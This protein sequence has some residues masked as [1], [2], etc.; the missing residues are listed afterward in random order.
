MTAKIKHSFRA[1]RS[2]EDYLNGAIEAGRWLRSQEHRT[3][4]GSWWEPHPSRENEGQT[5][6][7]HGSAGVILFFISLA[8][9]SGDKSFLDDAKRGADY[10][11]NALKKHG[12]D[13]LE[14][15]MA[16]NHYR[17]GTKYT[18]ISGGAAGIAYA[19]TELNWEL[20][21]PEE[22]YTETA[23]K[24]TE[25]IIDNA[26]EIP[27]GITWSRK[28]GFNF[29]SGTILYLLYAAEHY[30]HPEWID[31]AVK[32]GK[33]ILSTG[34]KEETGG[35]RFIGF[36][37]M[38]K[39]MIGSD[40]P[41]ADVPNF[42]YGSA[43]IGYTFA[44]LYQASGD[45]SFLDGAREAARY[46]EGIAEVDG[47]AALTPYRL[48]DLPDV[49]YLSSCHGIIG[50]IRLFKILSDIT[51][52]SE[53]TEWIDKYT[54][55]FKATGA[56]ELHS[57]GYWNCHS[58]CCGN[59]GYTDGFAGLYLATGDDRFLDLVGRNAAVMLADAHEEPEGISWYQAF[60]RIDPS[61]VSREIGYYSGAAG[62]GAALITAYLAY[63]GKAPVFRLLE[64]PYPAR[65]EE[66]KAA[67][68]I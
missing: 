50:T 44:R 9:A 66:N 65:G 56:P 51:G 67:A 40:D 18:L 43:G 64:E 55:G 16:G 25:E 37:N 27:E 39:A 1:K 3:D 58:Y 49:H 24:L 22:R 20:D 63:K 42:C 53:Y 5:D 34:M 32:A 10:T 62:I 60:K 2:P 48:P 4:N 38:V 13:F 15:G 47:D 29:D 6:L 57:N 8:D 12:S 52:E 30:G 26:V 21:K 14:S 68:V 35:T 61:D 31:T 36:S 11:V 54:E 41:K 23:L 46:L 59:A 19:L 28:S 33:A 17:S 7:M 45:E